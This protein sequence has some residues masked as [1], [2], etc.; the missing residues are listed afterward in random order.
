MNESASQEWKKRRTTWE[1]QTYKKMVND[2]GERKP[3]FRNLSEVLINPLYTPEDI[4]QLDY[5]TRIGFPGEYP[6]LRGVQP[7]MY[8]GKLW[9]MRQFAGFGS[10]EE[11]NQ[12][13]K[14][15]LAHGET[16]LSVAFDYPTL[17]GYDT[18]HPLARGEFGKCGVAVSSLKDMEILFKDIPVDKI[19]FIR[20][21]S[22]PSS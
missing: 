22:F 16:G 6:F 21:T 9:T 3:V 19:T 10:A 1:T 11:T 4:E 14:Y 18:D 8:R 5:L 17:Y 20:G 7:T 12:R 15:L 2:A 13:Y